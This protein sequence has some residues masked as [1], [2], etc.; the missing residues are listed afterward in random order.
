MG[1][2][3]LV[4]IEADAEPQPV[5]GSPL[6]RWGR[7]LRYEY[8]VFD[9]TGIREPGMYRVEYQ[10]QRTSP[11]PIGPDVYRRDVWQPTLETYFPVQMCHVKVRDFL[12]VWHGACHVE[13]AL[14]ASPD[15]P[16]RDGYHQGPE[17]ETRFKPLEHVP[18]LDWGGW[19]DA[20]DFDLP[21]GAVAG[22]AM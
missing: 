20:G 18:G 7:F 16:Q 6:V 10:G 21:A 12:I 14:Q 19:H 3:A 1:R 15:S 11:F 5:A 9:F 4:R 13:D 17:T 2:A 8:G 22:S